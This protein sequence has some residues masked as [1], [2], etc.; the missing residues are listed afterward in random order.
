MHSNFSFK[1]S[2]GI[3]LH[4]TSLPSAYGIGELGSS[5]LQWVDFLAEAKQNLWQVM[6]LG[7]TG[8]GNS[9]YQCFSA[10][11]GNPYF[12]SLEVLLSEGLLAKEQLS[13][14]PISNFP[15]FSDSRVDYEQVISFKLELLNTSYEIFKTQTQNKHHLAFDNFCASE[16]YWLNDYAFFAAAKEAH[17]GKA[18]QEWPADIRNREAL[19]VD[20][21]ETKL[22]ENI[23]KHKYWQWLFFSQ[24]YKIK[25]YANTKGIS[26]I[27][28]VPIFV[29][30]DSTDTWVNPEYFYLDSQGHPTV[31]AG[32]PPD[33][34]SETGQRW[35]NPLYNWQV[36][37]K[38]G[39][40]WWLERLKLALK[41]FDIVRIDHF[42][43]LEA[44]WE[45][46][47]KESTAIKGRWVKGPNQKF[48]DAIKHE[49]TGPLPVIAEDLGVITSEVE[50]LRDD[51]GLLGMKVLQF[52][53]SDASNAYLPHNY[54][55]NSVV[56]TGTHDND[57]ILGWF[58]SL[59]K[60]EKSFL[61]DYIVMSNEGIAWD[62]IRLAYSS[63]A[64]LAITTLQ[65]VL[66]LGSDSRMNTPNQASGNWQWRFKFSDI[67]EGTIEQLKKMV[68]IYGRN[69]GKRQ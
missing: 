49:I 16:S 34:F 4:P 53:F 13:N 61:Q 38:Q 36:M 26:I 18:W 20:S 58:T 27:G 31:V 64:V 14:L 35:G 21:W 69:G 2:A 15:K 11:A 42:R 8:Y 22:A 24:W 19:A 57:T 25:T 55:P 65:D 1:R 37:Q 51:N 23:T 68:Q 52:A 44:Y 59:S 39:F 67:S 43:G 33:Y 50:K 3:I 5:A 40:S 45:I 63:P 48:F 54:L 10:F 17:Q 66:S 6:P 30:S 60:Q 32:V 7:P 62:L 47:A 46:P 9:P 56:Y 12:I 29:A 41:L 28:D